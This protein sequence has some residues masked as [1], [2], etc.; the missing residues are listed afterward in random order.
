M[1]SMAREV[2]WD[3]Y[4][5]PTRPNAGTLRIVSSNPTR[6][7]T[8]ILTFF[9]IGRNGASEGLETERP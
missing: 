8:R 6:K 2:G 5:S 7:I 9:W 1:E 3:G 4:G